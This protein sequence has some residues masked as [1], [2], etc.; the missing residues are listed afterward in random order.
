MRDQKVE[1]GLEKEVEVFQILNFLMKKKW[2][3]MI[4]KTKNIII[5]DIKSIKIIKVI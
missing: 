1:K 3:D 5:I 2:K 4:I